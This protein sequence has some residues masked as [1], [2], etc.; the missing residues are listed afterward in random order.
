M[1]F[2]GYF[3]VYLII[4]IYFINVMNFDFIFKFFLL[5]RKKIYMLKLIVALNFSLLCHDICFQCF[6]PSFLRAD[7][8]SMNVNHVTDAVCWQIVFWQSYRLE[9]LINKLLAKWN[10]KRFWFTLHFVYIC[11]GEWLELIMPFQRCLV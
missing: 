11:D 10:H 3:N 4:R 6:F 2:Q 8:Y 7:L 5:Q 1:C 9:E